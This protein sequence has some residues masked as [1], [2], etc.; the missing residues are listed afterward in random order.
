MKQDGNVS[1]FVPLH[2]PRICRGQ[3]S[4]SDETCNHPILRWVDPVLGVFFLVADAG[5]RAAHLEPADAQFLEVALALLAEKES[6]A[7]ALDHRVAFGDVGEAPVLPRRQEHAVLQR[8]SVP[9]RAVHAVSVQICFEFINQLTN[10]I[11]R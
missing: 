8:S 9:F 11:N 5:P 10:Q 4:I 6:A 1:G 2:W 3:P 7:V